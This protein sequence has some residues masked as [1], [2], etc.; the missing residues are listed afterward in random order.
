ML[1]TVAGIAG[2]GL[3]L[4][5]LFRAARLQSLQNYDAW[6]FWVPKGKAIYLFGDLDEQVFTNTPGPSYPPLLPILDAASF[7]AMGGV[8]VV[9]LHLQFWFLVVG[10]IAAIAACLHGRVPAWLLWPSLVLVLVVPRFGER[11]LAP[12]ADVLVDLL[13]V[14]GAL[15]VASWLKDGEAWRLVTATTLLSAGALTKR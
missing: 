1:V 5:A 15:L 9:T 8:D 3:A 6:A 11:L 10:G 4:E 13:F 12:Q 14:V 2:A 7:H